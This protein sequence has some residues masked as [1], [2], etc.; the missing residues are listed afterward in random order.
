MM[1]TLA[2]KVLVEFIPSLNAGV[3]AFSPCRRLFVTQ[4][5][6]EPI[7]RK[8]AESAAMP[9]LASGPRPWTTISGV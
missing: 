6:L 9:R 5:G 1:D 7:L 3:D 2:G 4:P 8:R